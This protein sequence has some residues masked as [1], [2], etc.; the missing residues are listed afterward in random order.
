MRQ[1]SGVIVSNYTY[2]SARNLIMAIALYKLCQRQLYHCAR[3]IVVRSIPQKIFNY[4]RYYI[5][6]GL[7]ARS[8]YTQLHAI[9][10][11]CMQSTLSTSSHHREPNSGAQRH[12]TCSLLLYPEPL[13]FQMLTLIFVE[14]INIPF[15]KS[16]ILICQLVHVLIPN[17]TLQ[18]NL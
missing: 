16:S 4:L 15:T 12:G 3:R 11:D 6:D 5:P 7:H 18:C 13:R 9:Y 17:Y 10:I 8:R 2:I 1:K 14:E